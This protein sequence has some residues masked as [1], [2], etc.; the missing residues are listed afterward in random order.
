MWLDEVEH[1]CWN[2]R[3]QPWPL[4]AELRVRL[5]EPDARQQRLRLRQRREE[6]L[7]S[8][9]VLLREEGLRPEVLR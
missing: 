2:D 4:F 3:S 9:P 8:W 1:Y 7:R 5:V 6:L